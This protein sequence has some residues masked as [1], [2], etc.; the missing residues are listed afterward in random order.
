MTT[1]GDEPAALQDAVEIVLEEPAT[2]VEEALARR[3]TDAAEIQR[4]YDDQMSVINQKTVQAL[5]LIARRAVAAGE[6]GVASEAWEAVLQVEPENATAKNF[7]VAIGQW[8]AM[9]RKLARANREPEASPRKR[10]LQR[11]E[12]RCEDGRVFKNSQWNVE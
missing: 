9:E 2:T 5:D 8:D 11:V 3:D 7:F 10:T 12:F 1:A 6:I 4:V